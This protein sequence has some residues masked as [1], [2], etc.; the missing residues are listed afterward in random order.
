MV[1]MSTTKKFMKD[2]RKYAEKSYMVAIR[3]HKIEDIEAFSISLNEYSDHLENLIRKGEKAIKEKQV[4]MGQNENE[5]IDLRIEAY[6]VIDLDAHDVESY[7]DYIELA[8]NKEV[9]VPVELRQLFNAEKKIE[10]SKEK[11]DSLQTQVE[12]VK[13]RISEVEFILQKIKNEEL[14][15]IIE[16]E[17]TSEE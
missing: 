14:N 5:L 12:D 10:K 9:P 7:P 1:S 6:N 4:L 2:Y 13:K 3:D 11:I 8:R 15:D 17:E 16:A